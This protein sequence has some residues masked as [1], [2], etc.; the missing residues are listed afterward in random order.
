MVCLDGY[1]RVKS[2]LGLV[3]HIKDPGRPGGP[4]TE[5]ALTNLKQAKLPQ[6]PLAV[7]EAVLA[8]ASQVIEQGISGAL[9]EVEQQLFKL[10]EQAK[11]NEA[12]Q[13]CFESLREI[14]RG[15][16]DVVPRFVVRLESALAQIGRAADS[17]G[18]ARV[19][20]KNRDEFSLVDEKE[21]EESLALQEVASKAEIRHSQALFVLGQRFGVLAGSKAFE[22]DELPVGPHRLTEC[23]SRAVQALDVPLEHRV[24]LFR[25]FDRVAFSQLAGLYEQINQLCVEMKVLPNLQL[26]T[27]RGRRV[28]APAAATPAPR[29]KPATPT[30]KPADKPAEAATP[31]QAGQPPMPQAQPG[32]PGPANLGA[33]MPAGAMNPGAFDPGQMA[34]GL[35]SPL[36]PAALARSLAQMAAAG[37]A[38]GA[39]Q[40]PMPG[41]AMPQMPGLSPTS[42]LPS[43]PASGMP[44]MPQMP[45]MGGARGGMAR[46]PLS[47]GTFAN[48]LADLNAGPDVSDI[49]GAS[50]LRNPLMGWPGGNGSPPPATP[51]M[52]MG[53][54][55]PR[56]MELFETMRDLLAGRRHALGIGGQG[57]EN[58][59]SIRTD[60]VQS[61]LAAL[62]AKPVPNVRIG[63]KNVTRSVSHLKQDLIN[64]LRQLTPEGKQPTLEQVDNDTID[65]VGMLFDHL[66]KDTKTASPVQDFLTRLQIPL[67]R[68]ALRDKS[69]FTRRSH[70]AR[71]LLNSI[72]EAGLFWF[73]DEG[74]DR[75]LL[76]KMRLVVDRV[77]AE[78]DDNLDVFEDLLSD[79]S[80]HLST[81]ARKSEVAER[82]HVDAARG[83]ERL[84][85][86]RQAASQ[87]I[88]E[89]LSKRNVPALVKTLLEQAWT[90]VLALTILRQGE[91]SE[92]YQRRLHV[93]DQLLEVRDAAGGKAH[94][95]EKIVKS[96]KQEVEAGLSQVGYHVDDVQAVVQRLFG[97]EQQAANDDTAS[98]TELAIKLK[99]KSRLG[100]EAEPEPAAKP[101]VKPAAAPLSDEERRVMERL[102]TV[103]FGTW[104][105]FVVNQQGDSQRRKLSWFSTVTGRCLFVNQRGARTEERTIEQLAREIV[106]GTAR[107][108]EAAKD[109]LV[110]RAITSIMDTLRSFVGKAQILKPA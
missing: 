15:R 78:Y 17:P 77:T 84:D 11:S 43:M 53:G 24:L 96:L 37:A 10:A 76:E 66:L 74:D 19:T 81:V 52:E 30:D 46:D 106:R 109:S 32:M 34:G 23:F 100:G 48:E 38:P 97:G 35:Q 62:Q 13:R 2:E 86:A 44:S 60:D 33:G 75:Q 64:Q 70:P 9:N 95:D 87:A 103:P 104:F 110:D 3:M 90:D 93:A 27:P 85:L 40:M 26:A 98:L 94:V 25:A 31:P 92:S 105:E 29:A 71:Q 102:R 28:D 51:A 47:G 58:V 55:D 36:D 18:F 91:N 56:D 63:G 108:M 68:V 80:K 69:F 12:Q 45:P 21:F 88:N 59:H 65:L 79:L 54:A 61:V 73:D 99:S 8:A 82:R 89:R 49:P 4:G 16:S 7:L 101:A 5:E 41:A 57:G 39:P 14:R 50:G 72:T 83:R 1:N 22:S 20:R 107:V 42:G 67:L 6:R